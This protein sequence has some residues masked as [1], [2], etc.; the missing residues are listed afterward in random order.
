MVAVQGLALEGALDALYRKLRRLIPDLEPVT[1]PQEPAAAAGGSGGGGRGGGRESSPA[2]NGGYHISLS[3]SV[4]ITR[5]QIEPLTTQLAARLEAAGIGAFPLTLCGLRTFAND[6]GSRSFVSAMV[7]T[8]EREVVGLVRAVDGAFEAHGLPPFYQEPLPHV[9][10]GWLVGDQRPRIQAA[11]DRFTRQQ[12]AAAQQAVA[13]AKARA[14][15]S[16]ATTALL[17]AAAAEGAARATQ[18]AAGS[19]HGAAAAAGAASAFS[20]GPWQHRSRPPKGHDPWPVVRCSG[21]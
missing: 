20:L 3:R 14:Q 2:C 16:Q 19:Q 10:V 9:S 5:A 12:Q 8:G 17:V 1:K 15:S 21:R 18:P 7:A 13:Q 4:P 6:E 11:L